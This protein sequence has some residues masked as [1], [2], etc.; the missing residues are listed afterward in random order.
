MFFHTGKSISGHKK[1]LGGLIF[2]LEGLSGCPKVLDRVRNNYFTYLGCFLSNFGIWVLIF[3]FCQAGKSISRH[4]K[5]LGGFI[6]HLEGLLGCPEVLY[7]AYLGFSYPIP[8][9]EVS[10]GSWIVTW[11]VCSLR[12]SVEK[13]CE[14]SPVPWIISCVVC[15]LG[16][17]V[18]KRHN[19]REGVWSISCTMNHDWDKVFRSSMIEVVFHCVK[20][21]DPSVSC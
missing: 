5:W 15:W 8:L 21:Q 18:Q 19:D 3:I 17:G 1:R 20:H 6:L 16:L 11:V 4:Q 2:H 12:L 14:A 10:P 7:F 9:R 13:V